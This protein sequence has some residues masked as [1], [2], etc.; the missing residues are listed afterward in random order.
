MATNL[1]VTPPLPVSRA[2]LIGE[3]REHRAEVREAARQRQLARYNKEYMNALTSTP[4]VG[5]QLNFSYN[6]IRSA[7]KLVFSPNLPRTAWNFAKLSVSH[8]TR[9]IGMAYIRAFL[10]GNG[11]TLDQLANTKV[12]RNVGQEYT[13]LAHSPDVKKI[14]RA[15]THFGNSVAKQFNHLF[16][17]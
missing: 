15:F 4:S 12:V 17:L 6:T 9:K 3:R 10:K 14:S 11:H 8:D 2:V 13:D 7:H 5:Q 16:G 1:P